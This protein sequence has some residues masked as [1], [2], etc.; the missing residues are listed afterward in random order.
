MRA[1]KLMTP[2]HISPTRYE[3]FNK[4][5]V[6]DLASLMRTPMPMTVIRRG[7]YIAGAFAAAGAITFFYATGDVAEAHSVSKPLA[8]SASSS[9]PLDTAVRATVKQGESLSLL[10]SRHGVSVSALVAVNGIKD[11]DKIAAGSQILIPSNK[12]V[13]AGTG[14]KPA[15]VTTSN[16]SK[17][18][19]EFKGSAPKATPGGPLPKE[20]QS[21]PERR[22][23]QKHF[24]TAA[25]QHGVPADLLKAM[26]WQESGWQNG[27][28]SSVGA[29][30]VGQLMPDTVT[31]V[32]QDLLKQNLDPDKPEQNIKMSAAYL[33]FLLN[34]T[35]GDSRLA[36]AAY[37]QGLNAVQQRGL[38]NDTQAYV[39]DVLALQARYF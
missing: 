13:A 18:K 38:Y 21:S 24:D 30:G 27:V 29:Q 7:R 23:L 36:L 2:I 31:H 9:A 10:A 11:P 16:L 19:A 14:Q 37:Y 5:F 39:Q 33:R 1:S 25:R 35:D 32:N 6:R 4:D 22:A 3:P 26:S 12:Q 28:T 17:A 8:R 20:L 15:L 34:Q